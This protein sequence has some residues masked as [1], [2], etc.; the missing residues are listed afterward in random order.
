MVGVDSGKKRF[1]EDVSDA[2]DLSWIRAREVLVKSRTQLINAVH[3]EVSL[4]FGLTSGS[5]YWRKRAIP[6]GPN[7]LI[8]SQHRVHTCR[9]SSQSPSQGKVSQSL[10]KV[11][12]RW[13]TLRNRWSRDPLN[14]LAP[15]A[16]A[17]RRGLVP[18]AVA[19]SGPV[20]SDTGLASGFRGGI[21]W[22]AAGLP[23]VN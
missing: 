20:D 21:A 9:T 3:F 18:N 4:D 5:I 22:R 17:G 10:M 15:P 12:H 6:L 8:L 23:A 1:G 16:G 14:S 11:V 7:A 2:V 19:K 13:L